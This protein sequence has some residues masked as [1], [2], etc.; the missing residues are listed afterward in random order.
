MTLTQKKFKTTYKE[1]F[2]LVVEDT[3]TLRPVPL[4]S[5]SLEVFV[6]RH[7][8]EVV[9]HQLL[10]DSFIHTSQREIFSR[11]ITLELG[12]GCLHQTLHLN[13]L[14]LGDARTETKPL[15]ASSNTDSGGL[16]WHIIINVATDLG[17][18]HVAGVGGVSTDAMVFL[19]DGIEHLGKVLVGISISSINTTML[20]VKLN[21]AGDGLGQGEAGGGSLVTSELV[22]L[23][24]GHMLGHQG[25]LGLD[26]WELS[27][28]RRS[29]NERV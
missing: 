29:E 15:N 7:E 8:E 3:S 25:V 2:V 11:E 14:L 12:E 5:C 26:S 6:T 10:T 28:V 18:I 13:S 27:H 4:H 9:I 20:V 22:P 1:G 23:L 17:S 24:L 16:D 19:D 21:G